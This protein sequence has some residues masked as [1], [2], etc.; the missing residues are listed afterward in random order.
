ML[1]N[2]YPIAPPIISS[3]V[4]HT[5][6]AGRVAISLDPQLE[7]RMWDPM[8]GTPQ[9]GPKRTIKALLLTSAW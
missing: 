1:S 2:P 8:A 6:Q 3:M 5:V 4:R 7:H 9:W